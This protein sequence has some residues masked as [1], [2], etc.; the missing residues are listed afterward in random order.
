M[1]RKAKI[2]IRKTIRRRGGYREKGEN[3]WVARLNSRSPIDGNGNDYLE[4]RFATFVKLGVEHK[5]ESQARVTPCRKD[6]L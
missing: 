3:A 6:G 5:H 2:M 4:L 1:K